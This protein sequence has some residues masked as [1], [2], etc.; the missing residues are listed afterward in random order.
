MIPTRPD[1][2]FSLHDADTVASAAALAQHYA[3]LSDYYTRTRYYDLAYPGFHDI[4]HQPL[5][6]LLSGQLLNNVGDAYDE[7]HGRDHSKVQERAV[8]DY[9]ADLFRAPATR[10]GYVTT[11]SSEGTE[12]AL[13]D[14]RLAYPGQDPVVFASCA[15]HYSVVKAADRQRLTLVQICTDSGGRMDI[16]DLRTQLALF[17]HR[18]AVIVATVGTTMT[19]AYDDVAAIANV[20]DRLALHRRRI[21]V[22]AALSG[23]PLALLPDH[24]RPPFDFHAG[25]SS[26]VVSGHKFPSTLTPCAVLIYA[27]APATARTPRVPYT[28]TMDT[29]ITGSRSGHTPLLLWSSLASHGIAGHRQRAEKARELAAETLEKLRCAGWPAERG[30]HAFTV[31]L[32]QPPPRVLAKWVLAPDGTRAHI[33]LKPNTEPGVIDE[34]IDDLTRPENLLVDVPRPRPP[35][36]H[37]AAEVAA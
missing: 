2:P 18:P 20:C 35:A 15:A 12:H 10:W 34:F 24:D 31:V 14:A 17:R 1:P 13:Y 27:E 19:E 6:A 8:V 16:A 26:I 36:G 33:I 21:H 3:A 7:G 9:L 28:G 32:D 4:D 29:T 25:A 5:E 23:I 37:N 30:P 11:G 22:D